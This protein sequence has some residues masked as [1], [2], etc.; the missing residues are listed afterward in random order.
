ML[1]LNVIV[2]MAVTG[3][4][5]YYL[6]KGKVVINK[7]MSPEEEKK[8]LEEQKRLVKEHEEALAQY[9]QSMDEINQQVY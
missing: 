5:G 4:L 7:R 8:A 1:I 2:L 3:L 9:Q 6:G